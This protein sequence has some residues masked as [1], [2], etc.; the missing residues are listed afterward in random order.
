MNSHLRHQL[1]SVVKEALHNI[2]RHARANEVRLRLEQEPHELR[3]AIE[4]DGCGL[5]SDGTRV[6][7]H[8][9]DNMKKRVVDLGG[10]FT[11]TTRAKRGTRVVIRLPFNRSTSSPQPT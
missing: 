5:P 8:G 3:L 2:V 6:A 10:E 11:A 7:G 9:L 1:F 4:D